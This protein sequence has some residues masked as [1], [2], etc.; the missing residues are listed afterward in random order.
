VA[1]DRLAGEIFKPLWRFLVNEM[2]VPEQD[3]EE[4]SQDVLMKVHAK[5]SGFSRTGRAKLTTWIFTIATNRAIDF[6]RDR[7]EEHEELDEKAYEAR[8]RGE[9]AGRNLDYLEWLNGELEQ[10][11]PDDRQILLWR[12]Q[13]YSCAEIGGWLSMK[14]G[15][16]RVRHFRATRRILD[17]GNQAETLGV[18]SGHHLQEAGS[19]E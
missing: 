15:T 11:A 7:H 19:H 17:A 1:F 6:H 5:I 18:F 3:A 8:N 2:G 12:A 16:V 13:G 14:E 4:L 10:I 9:L